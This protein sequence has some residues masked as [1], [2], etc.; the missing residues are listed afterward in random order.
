MR[1]KQQ[2][3]L[4][5]D[6]G[7]ESGRVMAGLWDGKR[8]SLKELHRF[9]NGPVEIAGT[10][11]WDVLRLWHEIQQG[12]A[13]A[14]RAYGNSIQSVGVDT[15][16]VD[17]VLF[18]KSNELLAQPFHYRDARNRG[19]MRQAFKRVPRTEIFSE[20]GLQFM[21]F[22]TL[23]Q[24]LA[25]QKYNPELLEVADCLLMMPD[26]FH[27]CLSGIRVAEFTD[28]T[29]TQ[30]LNPLEKDWSRK[31]LRR[32]EL[33]TK[34]LPNIVPPGTVLGP[35]LDS[36]TRR[37]GLGKIDV[38]APAS[39]DTA[40]A[41]AA[42]PTSQQKEGTWCYLSSGT[43][44]LMGLELK[45][46]K[47]SQRVLDFNLTNEGGVDGTYRLLKNIT[48]LWLVQ[49]CKRAF[50]DSGKRLDYAQLVRLAK[51]AS[52]LRSFVDPDAPDFLN[53]P[54]MPAA[55]RQF[56][57]NIGQPVPNSDGALVRCALESMALKYGTVLD[58]L[59]EISMKPIEVIHIVG[60]GSRNVLLNQF[61]A[62]ACQRP[63]MAGPVEATVLG[64]LLLQA[65][66]S[67]EIKS[68]SELRS[69]VRASSEV[70]VFEP[71]RANATAW[72]E[73]R[74]RFNALMLKTAS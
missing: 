2:C 32:F 30:F 71:K 25:V 48:G 62:D 70:Q 40:S 10:L 50:D 18:S 66:A 27:W 3:Y 47:L 36:V 9:P 14:A 49:Q 64:N 43:W 26:F 59:Q 21:E 74:G 60:G 23:F 52:A 56:C 51:S 4:G 33:P 28:A 57:R 6:L 68:L 63:V 34:L 41:V 73:A 1:V 19:M 45:Q 38:I 35:M 11:R 13:L 22:N 53:P 46:A 72:Q 42:V 55:L 54:Y 5:I 24:L 65:R 44:S 37:T 20:T 16:G 8:M 12:L 58:C 29:T 31:L 15:W 67:G 39:H 7:A 61:T 69:I 17:Y